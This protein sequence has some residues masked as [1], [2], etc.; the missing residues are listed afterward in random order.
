MLFPGPC[1]TRLQAQR[2]KKG[3]GLVRSLI[4][5]KLRNKAWHMYNLKDDC[6][7]ILRLSRLISLWRPRVPGWDSAGAAKRSYP[8]P[9]ARGGGPEEQPHEQRL[10]GH[11]RA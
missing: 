7:V 10:C 11:R 3:P 5:V 6:K 2:C 1:L 8:M 4:D 9:E